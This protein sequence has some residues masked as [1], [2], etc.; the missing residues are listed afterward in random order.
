M[1][2]KTV[3]YW[4]TTTPLALELLVG[5]VL[6]LTR[7]PYAVG[8]MTHLGYPIYMLTILGIWKLLGAIAVL[9]PG[10]PRLKEW[11]Y[12][13]TIFNMT[14]AVVSH[15]VCGDG[16]SGFLV[17]AL[18]AVLA[19]ASWALRSPDRALQGQRRGPHR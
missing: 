2:S 11:A 7:R 17:P 18:F 3:A 4:V 6:D 1:K 5:S 14:G 19:I 15:I 13:G 12:A 16:V 10:Y 8:L 9:A